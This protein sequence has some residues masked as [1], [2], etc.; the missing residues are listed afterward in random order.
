[1]RNKAQIAF[2]TNL[3]LETV[4]HVL[5]CSFKIAVLLKYYSG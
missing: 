2:K 5:A 4:L 1:M 3:S